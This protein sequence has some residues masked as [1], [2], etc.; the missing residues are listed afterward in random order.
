MDIPN[1]KPLRAPL[2]VIG[3]THGQLFDLLEA[4][5]VGGPPPD[6]NY[7]FLGGY[8]NRGH[9]GYRNLENDIVLT[10]SV[11]TLCLLLCL[12]LRYPNRIT[13]L[14]G[15]E[16]SVHFTQVRYFSVS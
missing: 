12:Q 10:R 2:S 5:R 11:E 4:F 14:R 13:L 1:V 8:V 16:D 3:N 6:V 7:V 9:F 15:Y